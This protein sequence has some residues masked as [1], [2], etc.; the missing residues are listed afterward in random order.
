MNNSKPEKVGKSK[1]KVIEKGYDWGLYIWM[2]PNGKAFGDGHGNLLT[3]HQ[4]VAI[5]KKWLS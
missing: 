4:C 5:Y 3:Y 2:K 1:L